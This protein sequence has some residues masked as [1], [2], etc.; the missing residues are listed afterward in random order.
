MFLHS[1]RLRD[2]KSKEFMAKFL[3]KGQIGS[4]AEYFDGEK[5]AEWNR[6]IEENLE[7]TDINLPSN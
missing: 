5:L 7:G 6:W 1:D 2:E 4:Y 3:R